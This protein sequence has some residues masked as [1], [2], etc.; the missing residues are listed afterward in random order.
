MADPISTSMFNLPDLTEIGIENF[1][2][3]GPRQTIKFGRISFLFGPNSHGKTSVI[4]VINLLLVKY[5]HRNF[6]KG[7]LEYVD[8]SASLDLSEEL[9]NHNT[10]AGF[11]TVDIK[12]KVFFPAEPYKHDVL[13]R[14]FIDPSQN[15]HLIKYQAF[16]STSRGNEL[17][18]E[19][20]ED[21]VRLNKESEFFDHVGENLTGPL[22]LNEEGVI[23]FGRLN[24]RLS[25]LQLRATMI[26]K[27][28]ES[29][30][31]YDMNFRHNDSLN[32]IEYEKIHYE[33][34]RKEKFVNY[35]IAGLFN[36]IAD[37]PFLY[38]NKNTV[39]FIGPNR[40]VPAKSYSENG[41]KDYL[42]KRVLREE[43]VSKLNEWLRES[44]HFEFSYE[45]VLNTG[46][47]N[48]T[49]FER[50]PVRSIVEYGVRDKQ[51]QKMLKFSEV[52]SGIG[53]IFQI[54]LPLFSGVKVY[55]IQQP[56]VHLHPSLQVQLAK[57][58]FELSRDKNVQLVIETHSEHFIK[59]AQLEV[60]KSKS[61]KNPLLTQDD[62]KV[63]YVS[64]NQDGHS[65]VRNI[66]INDFGAFN[67]PW[68]DDFFELSGDLSLGRL[69][70]A[71]QKR[72]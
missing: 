42:S 22:E 13:H 68:P 63:I 45:F 1:K 62:L 35:F 64:K 32:I 12:R 25:M 55:V 39:L 67:E 30:E 44:R 47:R 43:Y 51:N 8:N 60:A 10:K 29:D 14:F 38:G 11:F 23:R 65:V 37:L 26:P 5:L 36:V 28:Y 53:H 15:A 17:I 54:L 9:V 27:S 6:K 56:E 59:A 40:S 16:E 18:V 3:F 71:F 50:F 46:D 49:S 20:E 24:M 19:I 7:A 4:A 34:D 61:I 21:E 52:G 69:R 41:A 33:N 57:A 58:L 66:Q 2:S 72:N 70:F 31:D 48:E